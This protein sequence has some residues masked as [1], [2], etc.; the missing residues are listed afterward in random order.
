[1]CVIN[2]MRGGVRHGKRKGAMLV[3]KG[4]LGKLEHLMS[5]GS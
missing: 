4:D 2:R 1:M 3:E 5:L